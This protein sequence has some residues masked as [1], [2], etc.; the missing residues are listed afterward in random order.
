MIV[1]R[2]TK[3]IPRTYKI[4]LPLLFLAFG[5]A[6]II[7]FGSASIL[8]V[9]RNMQQPESATRKTDHSQNP[10]SDS[11]A[12]KVDWVGVP[13]EVIGH[14][15]VA[16]GDN[17]VTN[18]RNILTVKEKDDRTLLKKFLEVYKN[19]PDKVNMCGIR[20]SHALA[21]FTTVYELQPTTVIE[22]GVNAGQS[23]YFI[24]HAAPNTKIIAIDPLEKP[25]CGQEKRWMDP[26]GKTEYLTGG[27]FKDLYD[28]DWVAMT[29]KK[30]IDPET[31]LAFFDDHLKVLTRIPPLI[32]A[33]IRHV[34]VEDNYSRGRGATPSDKAGMTPKQLFFSDDPN[35]RWLWQNMVSY[36][37]FP[38]IVPSIMSVESVTQKKK[39]AGGFMV[40]SDLNDDT[41]EPI[42]RPDKDS[43]DMVIY[44]EMAEFL[45][46]D[47]RLRDKESYMQFMSYNFICY[48]ELVPMAP[49]ILDRWT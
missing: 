41:M 18:I 49:A 30:E 35:S 25:I 16:K 17:F 47:P 23:T 8:E 44:R 10:K 4:I 7:A 32:K 45:E 3:K 27:K 31:T 14:P 37:E 26:S 12:I 6:I 48:F 40:A 9:L 22:S 24:R 29:S 13:K 34:I 33:G 1:S 36:R 5:A 2:K 46:M 19:R 28:I 20:I 43:G 38:P 21:L 15:L 42:L 11:T 39:P